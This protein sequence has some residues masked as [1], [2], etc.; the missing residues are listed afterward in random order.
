MRRFVV[1]PVVALL[2]VTASVACGQERSTERT[3]HGR[4]LLPGGSGSRGVELIV[5]TVA[6][7]GDPR[8]VWLR[9]DERGDFSHRFE[10]RVIRLIVTAGIGREVH[11]VDA[12]GMPQA[13][14]E[15]RIDMG[16]KVIIN[17]KTFFDGHAPPDRVH[18]AML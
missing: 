3:L 15:G 17:I 1:T 4:L 8:R 6:G 13:D 12:D 2:V 10:G 5:T 7:D 9:F 16:E 14:T 18:A 11:R